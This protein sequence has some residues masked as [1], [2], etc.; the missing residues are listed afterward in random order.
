MKGDFPV[1]KFSQSLASAIT[2]HSGHRLRLEI[3][4]DGWMLSCVF[5]DSILASGSE[6]TT[7]DFRQTLL[8]CGVEFEVLC[9][10]QRCLV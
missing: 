7:E 10:T 5:C 6:G 4:D 9:E 1:K 8:D 3:D 2:S